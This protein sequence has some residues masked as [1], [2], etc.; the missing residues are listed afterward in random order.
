M[1]I[2]TYQDCDQLR[3]FTVKRTCPAKNRANSDTIE[4]FFQEDPCMDLA[5]RL[6][7]RCF[8]ETPSNESARKSKFCQIIWVTFI[9]L[10]FHEFFQLLLI[11]SSSKILCRFFCQIIMG[12]LLNSNVPDGRSVKSVLSKDKVQ[13]II[14]GKLYRRAVGTGGQKGNRPLAFGSSVKPI[15]SR[16]VDYAPRFLED[17]P[18]L[19]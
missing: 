11:L 2:K 12:S 10:W 15:P 17:V 18:P 14:K 8:I 6:I 19:I 16:V 1:Q 4:S 7:W 9:T 13:V 5:S 3:P